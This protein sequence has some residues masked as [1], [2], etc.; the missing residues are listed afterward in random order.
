[1]YERIKQES[2]G[3]DVR[4]FF[5]MAL[6]EELS[7]AHVAGLVQLLEAAAPNAIDGHAYNFKVGDAV[8]AT[9]EFWSPKSPSLPHLTLGTASDAGV[10]NITALAADQIRAS[11]RK[12]AG[13]FN[14]PV[15]AKNLNLV[16]AESDKH[17]DIDICEACFGTEEE[18]LAANGRHRWHRLGDGVFAEAGITERVVGLVALRRSDPSRPVSFYEAF[19]LINEPH[20]KWVDQI[21]KAIPI[22]KVVR[23][24]MRP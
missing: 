19:L 16:V 2:A 8:L 1:V 24:N 10:V 9:V 21:T 22:A 13:A 4:K 17:D 6:K 23:Y 3:I 5:G 18:L 14:S 12:A 11:L 15:D 20:L 7:E